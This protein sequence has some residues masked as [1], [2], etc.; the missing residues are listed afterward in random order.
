M[1]LLLLR[2]T[3]ASVK[4]KLKNRK[5]NVQLFAVIV[6]TMLKTSSADDEKRAF[7]CLM[8]NAK[9]RMTK[10]MTKVMVKHQP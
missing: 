5:V 7:M 1:R 6:T 2:L 4:N 8:M 9:K 3:R 10:M